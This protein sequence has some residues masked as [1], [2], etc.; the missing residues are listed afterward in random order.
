MA[1]V[2]SA[3]GSAQF[4]IAEA[5]DQMLFQLVS[6][7]F[8]TTSGFQISFCNFCSKDHPEPHNHSLYSLHPPTPKT[9]AQS[10]CLLL[11]PFTRKLFS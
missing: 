5:K 2:N 7:A 6:K 8:S 3:G 9:L 1:S 11:L 4:K 10:R